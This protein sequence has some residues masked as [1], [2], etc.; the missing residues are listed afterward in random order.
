MMK[1]KVLIICLAASVAGAGAALAAKEE[2]GEEGK[3]G[4]RKGRPLPKH[5][6]EKYD[7][8][9]DGTLSE[10]EKAEMRKAWEARRAE[11]MKK[12]DTDGDGKLSE[13]EREAAREARKKAML[14][15]YDTDKNGELSEE[16]K[17]AARK[18]GARFGRP[19]GKRG[20]RG[21]REV[22]DKGGE[23]TEG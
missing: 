10:A 18:D 21:G 15:K 4:D 12:Y 23:A 20:G 7:T 2:G 6:I 17:E 19:R 22:K 11:F 1:S 14:E 9:K 3:R 13:K 5:V 16:E 8:D